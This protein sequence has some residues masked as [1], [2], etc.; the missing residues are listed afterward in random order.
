MIDSLQIKWIVGRGAQ[1]KRVDI[2]PLSLKERP[3]ESYPTFQ[4]TKRGPRIITE[5]LRIE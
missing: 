4:L 2:L 1:D 5:G 3:F